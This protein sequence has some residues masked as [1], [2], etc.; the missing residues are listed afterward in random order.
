M[1][2]TGQ[3]SA[4]GYALSSF[5]VGHAVLSHVVMLMC[6]LSFLVSLLLFQFHMRQNFHKA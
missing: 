3:V 1:G 6:A 2:A 5:F 4:V